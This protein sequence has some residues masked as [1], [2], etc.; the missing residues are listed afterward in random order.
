MEHNESCF[1]VSIDRFKPHTFESTEGDGLFIAHSHDYDELTLILRGEGYY[2]SPTQNLKVS[3]GSLIRIPPGLHHGFVC[4][5]PWQGISVHFRHDKLPVS[6]QY[7]FHAEQETDCIYDTKLN[8]ND[9]RWAEMSLLQLDQEWRCGART[10]DSAN[11]MRTAME[12]AL[13]LF[14]RSRESKK[15]AA[16][17][18]ND[19]TIVQEVLKEI[20]AAYYSP[21]TVHELAA[22]HFLSESNLRK[23][24]TEAIGVSPKQYIINLRIKEAKRLLRQTDKAIEAISSEVGF[25][26]SSRFYDYFVKSA[27]VTPLEWR[28]QIRNSA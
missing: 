25:T 8:E 3:A 2:S 27:G 17:P 15:P 24:F 1:V 9:M 23:K 18:A 10:I 16:W 28:K 4:T 26:S 13:L 22:R 21:I 19:H 12:T 20:H 5:D 7:L 6:C 14:Q 11:L